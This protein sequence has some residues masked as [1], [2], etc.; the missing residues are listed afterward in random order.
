MLTA[1][2]QRI[3]AAVGGSIGGASR[4]WRPRMRSGHPVPGVEEG[5]R[6]PGR[7]GCRGPREPS[8]SRSVTRQARPRTPSCTSSS[9]R[10]TTAVTRPEPSTSSSTSSPTPAGGSV[11]GL[12]DQPDRNQD[13]GHADEA[14]DGVRAASG[15]ACAAGSASPVSS[16]S[17]RSSS[18]ILRRLTPPRLHEARLVGQ[19]HRLDAVAQAELGEYPGDVGL[20]GGVRHDQLARRSRRWRARGRPARSTSIS[21]SVSSAS[22][23]AARRPAAGGARSPRSAAA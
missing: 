8:G 23:R 12:P 13:H 7:A 11:E 14:H 6:R 3:S 16:R 5:H 2:E 22:R 21:R 10:S 17:V 15:R 1:Q 4:A 9:T 20:D 18:V 19:H